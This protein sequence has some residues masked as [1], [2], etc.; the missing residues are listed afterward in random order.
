MWASE[1]MAERPWHAPPE[2]Q[3]DSAAINKACLEVAGEGVSII[4]RYLR[5]KGTLYRTIEVPW[6]SVMLTGD[7]PN[8]E[9]EIFV[10]ETIR[11]LC[12]KWKNFAN[13][14]TSRRSHHHITRN[15]MRSAVSVNQE[16]S[17]HH[18]SV[19]T[20]TGVKTGRSAVHVRNNSAK[21]RR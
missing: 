6:G 21:I 12:K 14:A 1:Q 11:K 5:D 7:R 15:I 19:V 4:L 8:G 16:L 9:L 17:K 13:P 2:Q 20:T 10:R 18:F 3:Q